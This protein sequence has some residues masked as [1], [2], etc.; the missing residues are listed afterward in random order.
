VSKV[1]HLTAQ[2]LIVGDHVPARRTRRPSPTHAAIKLAKLAKRAGFPGVRVAPDGS[3]SILFDRPDP[4]VE[5]P[6]SLKDLI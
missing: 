2:D 4:V 6:E 3:A 5:T 1:H